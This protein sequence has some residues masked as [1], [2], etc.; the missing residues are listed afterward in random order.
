MKFILFSVVVCLC[1]CG[2]SVAESA[3]MIRNDFGTCY[4]Y[5]YNLES[6]EWKSCDIAFTE[7]YLIQGRIGNRP[8]IAD[9]VAELNRI[10][11]YAYEGEDH[12]SLIKSAGSTSLDDIE[13]VFAYFDGWIYT[14]SED[15]IILRI[16]D[17][18]I[19]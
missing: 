4:L 5:E 12:C 18:K 3:L 7:P 1:I 11:L 2:H 14:V 13:Y 19:C 6:T 16:K 10:D 8:L 17:E 15:N 9:Y